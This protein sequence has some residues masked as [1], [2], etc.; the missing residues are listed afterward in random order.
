MR[1]YFLTNGT[2]RIDE[3]NGML[4]SLSF[5]DLKLSAEKTPLFTFGLRLAD[6]EQV[7]LNPVA[8]FH[9]TGVCE[10]KLAYVNDEYDLRVLLTLEQTEGSIDWRVS[11]QNGSDVLIEWVEL[12][13]LILPPLRKNGG[14]GRVLYPYNEGALVDDAFRREASWF[15]PREPSYP[16]NGSYPV[17]PNMLCSQ[18]MCYLFE[19]HG[20]YL[21]AHD[22]TRGVKYIDFHSCP[23]GIEMI[24]RIYTG[25]D[26]GDSYCT[27]FPIRWEFF[28]GDWQSGAEIYRRFFENNLPLGAK[29]T[30]ENERLPQW[31]GDAPLIV[32]YP[33]R[34]VHD[35]DEMK[36]NRLFPYCNALPHLD[37]IAE[38]TGARLMALLMHWE[39]TAPWAPPYVMPPYGGAEA[40]NEFRD[41]LHARGHLLG[42][43]CSGFG[44]TL[45]S[46]LIESYALHPTSE[47]VEAAMCTGYDQ[48]VAI[49]NICTGQRKGYDICPASTRGAEILEEAY[50]PLFESGIDYAQILDQNHGG[51]QYFCHS[52]RHGHPA[53]PGAWMTKNM[54]KML[55]KWNQM[56]PQML[57]GCESAAAEPFIGNLGFSDNRFELN[58]RIGVPVP[59]YSFLYHEYLR[60]FMGNQVCAPFHNAP[61]ALNMRLSYSFAAGDS[62]TLIMGQDG[63]FL[64]AWGQRDFSNLPCREDALCLIRNLTAFYQTEGKK[65]LL[66]GRMCVGEEIACEEISYPMDDGATLTVPAVFSNVWEADGER[67]RIL[68]N[69][70]GHDVLCQSTHGEVSVPAFSAVL[71]KL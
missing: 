35:M 39:G 47:D 23:S 12:G 55:G 41:A 45:Q 10:K 29:K 64:S 34:G 58:Y 68:V 28:E 56:A 60:N 8:H 15:P 4:D 9:F 69:H 6:G 50:R 22:P 51:G 43:Y 37:D 57:F 44:Y 26:F 18:F 48:K 65:Y 3:S 19:G 20:L 5:E 59:L 62:M 17:F 1:T 40:M 36:P 21:G 70:T 27:D 24:F 71:Q 2:L 16:S 31:Y 30:I 54:Q 13:S 7:R 52:R 32:A 67:A 33:V 46:N 66:A 61:K 53:A 63:E 11:V 42:V 38:Q 14:I 25:I 49:S